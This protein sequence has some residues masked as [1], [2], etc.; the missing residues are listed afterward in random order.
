[1]WYKQVFQVISEFTAVVQEANSSD[2]NYA[3][4]SVYLKKYDGQLKELRRNI[5]RWATAN[6][7]RLQS[8]LRTPWL[9][10]I[11]DE[12]LI[13]AH[14]WYHE[15]GHPLA[16]LEMKKSFTER[17]HKFL[18]GDNQGHRDEVIRQLT[19]CR[20]S[21]ASMIESS[22][23]VEKEELE[24]MMFNAKEVFQDQF[25][26]WR[27]NPQEKKLKVAQWIKQKAG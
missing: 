7:W 12:V 18:T 8:F 4:K 17:L 5:L 24:A 27:I 15:Q 2:Q 10:A 6:Y 11:L 1:M 20:R 19:T 22:A 9:G 16:T 23:F 13:N 3:D 26:D 14:H 21:R 25:N